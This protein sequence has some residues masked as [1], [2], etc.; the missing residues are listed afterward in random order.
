MSEQE[1]KFSW[2]ESFKVNFRG[3]KFLCKRFPKMMLL[4]ISSVFVK[5]LM[6]YIEIYLS[7]QII[8]ELAGACRPEVLRHMVCILLA[9]TLLLGAV[10]SVLL[11]YHEAEKQ[12]RFM[13]LGSILDEKLLR[14]DYM[15]LDKAETKERITKIEQAARS[16]SWGIYHAAGNIESVLEAFCTVL[17]AVL[18][19]ASLFTSPIPETA[20]GLV[21][22]NHPLFLLGLLT[23]LLLIIYIGPRLAAKADYFWVEHVN[24]HVLGNLLFSFYSALPYD[25]EKAMDIRIYRQDRMCEEYIQKGVKTGAFGSQGLFAQYAKKTGGFYMAASGMLSVLC[26]GI[27]YLYVC[28]KAW[29]GAFGAG[30]VTQ[31]IAA[32]T[33]LAKGLSQMVGQIE[34]MRNNAPFL[35]QLFEFL[36]IPN[37]MYKGSLSVEKRMDQKYEIEFRDVGFCYPGSKTWALRHVSFKFHVGERLAVVGENG[38]G[39]TTFIKLLCRLYDPTEGEILLNGIRIDKYNYAEYMNLFSVVFQDFKLFALP[40]GENVASGCA[41]DRV[42][43][44]DCLVRAGFGERLQELPQGLDTCLYKETDAAGVDVSGGEAQKIALARALYKEAPFII[45]DEPT[46]ALDP[47]AESEIYT[48]FNEIVGDHTAIYISH[49]L[50]S[51]RFCDQIAVFDRGSIVESGSHDRLVGNEKGKYHALWMAQAQYYAEEGIEIEL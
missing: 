11:R 21:I 20:G 17:G 8:G 12:S 39:K 28:A 32:A 46:A 36:D 19:T 45:L 10:R 6:P 44:E 34:D 27:L 4:S 43:A 33:T 23:V 37:G 7:A 30:A 14:M 40:V 24:D 9:V 42:R 22:L 5:A 31:Y 25:R 35:K 15:E 29:A 1:K 2:R 26:T 41:V 13:K 51:C 18:L 3:F 48:R 38:S 50:S 16:A 49:R 47:V